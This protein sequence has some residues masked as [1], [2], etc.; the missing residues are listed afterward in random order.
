[1]FWG[2][3]F[4]NMGILKYHLNK[5]NS[6]LAIVRE[7]STITGIG[8][9]LKRSHKSMKAYSEKKGRS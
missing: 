8:D 9:R 2:L 1:M 6:E 7:S 5:S 4:G 3:I